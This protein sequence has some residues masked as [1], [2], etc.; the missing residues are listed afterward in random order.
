MPEATDQSHRLHIRACGA[1]TG[2]IR[3]GAGRIQGAHVPVK[4]TAVRLRPVARTDCARV[5]QKSEVDYILSS[6][7]FLDCRSSKYLAFD[8][9]FYTAMSAGALAMCQ[10]HRRQL[11][12]KITETYGGTV[13]SEAM[14]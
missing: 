6:A 8:E 11:P 2:L 5:G 4:G 14:V 1:K 3:I 12:A 10:T 13:A 9:Q 7:R